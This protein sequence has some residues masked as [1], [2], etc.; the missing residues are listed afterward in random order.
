MH[1]AFLGKARKESSI[2]TILFM[3][4]HQLYHWRHIQGWTS[5][6]IR[7]YHTRGSYQG[8]DRKDSRT[9]TRLFSTGSTQ[10]IQQRFKAVRQ[11]WKIH[12]LGK[13]VGTLQRSRGSKREVYIHTREGRQQDT[14]VTHRGGKE[15]GENT[16]HTLSGTWQVWCYTEYRH[17]CEVVIEDDLPIVM[18]VSITTSSVILTLL[19]CSWQ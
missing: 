16:K 5:A 6:N 1:D 11:G 10:C 17:G 7:Q 3:V 12:S 8:S 4:N 19:G 18:I 9:Q 14:G 13:D 2:I 15:Q